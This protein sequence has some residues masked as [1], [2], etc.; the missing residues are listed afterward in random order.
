[1]CPSWFKE[2]GG[3]PEKKEDERTNGRTDEREK[4]E[5]GIRLQIFRFFE[6]WVWS[7]G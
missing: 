6:G 5:E 2:T 4:K 7:E 3:F 1:V